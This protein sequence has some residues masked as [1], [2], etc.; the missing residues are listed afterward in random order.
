M[1]PNVETQ[2]FFGGREIGVN[3]KINNMYPTKTM[4]NECFSPGFK[5]PSENL[6][7][8]NPAKKPWI[9]IRDTKIIL[10]FVM[11]LLSFDLKLDIKT[12]KEIIP[13]DKLVANVSKLI[14]CA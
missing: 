6:P 2:A 11:I 7:T 9:I 14:N 8:S 13:N 12:I 5:L 4:I 3:P 1:Y 10:K